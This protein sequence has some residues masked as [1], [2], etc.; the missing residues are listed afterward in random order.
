MRRCSLSHRERVRVRGYSVYSVF[1]KPNHR[2]P[3][4][5]LR[6]AQSTLSLWERGFMVS[7][8]SCKVTIKRKSG[9]AFALGF[10][11]VAI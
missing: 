9:G 1:L 4:P 5:V 11:L 2:N 8:L 3:S 6:Y 10:S 7:Q